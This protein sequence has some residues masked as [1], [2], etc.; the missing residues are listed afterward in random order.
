[1]KIPKRPYKFAIPCINDIRGNL[2]FIE[3]ESHFPFKIQRVYWIYDVPGGKTRGGYAYK[4]LEEIII[5]LS[6]SFDLICIN[7]DN[8]KTCFNL[9]RSYQAIYVPGKTWRELSNFSTNGVALILASRPYEKEDYI[10]NYEE[11]EQL[12]KNNDLN[13]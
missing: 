12:I 1:M 4:K 11:F 9:N 2:S 7:S 6:G 13:L 8:E 3:N 10:Y 5:P